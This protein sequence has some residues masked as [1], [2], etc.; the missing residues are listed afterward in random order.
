[1]VDECVYTAICV[2]CGKTLGRSNRPEN[3]RGLCR[4]HEREADGQHDLFVGLPW[5]NARFE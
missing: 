4:E 5:Q 3:A 2:T 1:M